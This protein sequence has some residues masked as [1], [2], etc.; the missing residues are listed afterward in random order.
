MSFFDF[1]FGGKNRTN[2]EV[3]PERI[4]MTTAGKF[5][6]VIDGAQ[7][8]AESGVDVIL[9]VAHFQDV[10]KQL[11]ELASQRS[12][13]VP[14]QAVLASALEQGFSASPKMRES[15]VVGIIVAEPHPL[16]AED[17]A[18]E[19][20]ARGLSCRCR[21]SRHISLEDPVVDVFAGGWVKDML[22]KL[23]VKE[24]EAIESSA[25]TR[26]IR[27][28]QQKIEKKSF[29]NFSADSAAA[30]FEMNCPELLK[31]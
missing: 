8:L 11:E 10:L 18:V 16:Q 20:F 25:V 15:A 1:L 9:L 12:W 19:S 3:A 2:V 14:C 7:D 31:K 30:W 29:G 23:G 6:G 27:H 17:E 24:H 22:G 26:R 4:W 21:L 13:S 28:A 5:A